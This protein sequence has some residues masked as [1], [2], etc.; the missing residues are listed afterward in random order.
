MRF[1]PYAVVCKYI[2]QGYVRHGKERPKK[3]LP[4]SLENLPDIFWI[5][6]KEVF[7]FGIIIRGILAARALRSVLF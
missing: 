7:G 4:L 5:S 6:F 2:M 3:R 1:Q